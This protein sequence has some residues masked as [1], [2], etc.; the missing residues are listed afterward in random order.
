VVN[1]HFNAKRAAIELWRARV[2][3]RNIMKQL[4]M[5][6]ATLMR[7]WAFCQGKPCRPYC[8]VE[9]GEWSSHQAVCCHLGPHEEEAGEES[10]DSQPEDNEDED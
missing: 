1:K 9:E 6:K 8:S 4:G 7:V 10:N 2:P 3:Q 5:S